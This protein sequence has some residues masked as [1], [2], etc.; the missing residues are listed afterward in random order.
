MDLPEHLEWTIGAVDLVAAGE[1]PAVV[2]GPDNN[3]VITSRVV[4]GAVLAVRS[5]WA[6]DWWIF[7]LD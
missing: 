4:G 6:G 7:Q 2:A 1:H 3:F 5:M